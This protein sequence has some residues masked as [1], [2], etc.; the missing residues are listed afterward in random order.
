MVFV[1]YMLRTRRGGTG[2][3][4]LITNGKIAPLASPQ[5]EGV[6]QPLTW[7]GS[8]GGDAN[9]DQASVDPLGGAGTLNLASGMFWGRV[10]LTASHTG[11]H[12][13]TRPHADSQGSVGRDEVIQGAKIDPLGTV[14]GDEEAVAGGIDDEAVDAARIEPMGQVREK[15]PP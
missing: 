9:I 4:G 15:T 11:Q 10:M 6:K 2:P 12:Q 3:G 1:E 8:V 13:H 7:G 5:K 14:K